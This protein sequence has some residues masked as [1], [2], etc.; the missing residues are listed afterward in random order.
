MSM[1]VHPSV[2]LVDQYL[3]ASEDG[4]AIASFLTNSKPEQS[5]PWRAMLANSLVWSGRAVDY[6]DQRHARRSQLRQ[7]ATR[8]GIPE[9]LELSAK[10]RA[11]TFEA[12][13]SKRAP[14][15]Q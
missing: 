10:A 15:G 12:A 4:S 5:A 6:F 13:K 3:V 11:R 9:V 8:L 2:L 14:D 7:A 1:Y